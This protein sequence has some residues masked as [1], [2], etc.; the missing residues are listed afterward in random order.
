VGRAKYQNQRE[1]ENEK[2]MISDKK[3]TIFD[4]KQFKSGK[5]C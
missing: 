4:K 3:A 5:F 2:V 1:N